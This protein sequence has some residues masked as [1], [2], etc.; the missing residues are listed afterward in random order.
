MNMNMYEVKDRVGPSS[1]RPPNIMSLSHRRRYPQSLRWL[2]VR[3]CLC[4][5]TIEGV[6]AE[7][8]SGIIPF[9]Q[10]LFSCW[11]KAKEGGVQ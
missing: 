8:G 5:P 1:G 6:R 4:T 3:T 2:C 10:I 9:V 7:K 11:K